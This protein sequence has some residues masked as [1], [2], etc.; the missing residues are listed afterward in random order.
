MN[1][2]DAF[3]PESIMH[4]CDS[5]AKLRGILK[6]CRVSGFTKDYSESLLT[7]LFSERDEIPQYTTAT[8]NAWPLYFIQDRLVL[9]PTPREL[10]PTIVSPEAPRSSSSNIVAN[11]EKLS[12]SLPSHW[13]T[14]VPPQK[15]II[16]RITDQPAILPSPT[17][18]QS[19]PYAP[20]LNLAQRLS[21]KLR[22][23]GECDEALPPL[24]YAWSIPLRSE[25]PNTHPSKIS[26][27]YKVWASSPLSN[28][29]KVPSAE[30]KLR[31]LST[32]ISQHDEGV[33]QDS[34]NV[35]HATEEGELSAS[36]DD[37][38]VTDA[39][40]SEPADSPEI[41]PQISTSNQLEDR[42]TKALCFQ[43]IPAAIP[44]LPQRIPIAKPYQLESENS[45]I[46]HITHSPAD[47]LRS[48]LNI[49][50]T[51]P[52]QLNATNS[53]VL[54]I[55]DTEIDTL[56]SSSMARNTK[57]CQLRNAR[58]Q[59]LDLP[60]TA[61]VFSKPPTSIQKIYGPKLTLSRDVM[62]VATTF[63]D[64]EPIIPRILPSFLQTSLLRK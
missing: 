21:P 29:P 1:T 38:V 40:I 11:D 20:S 53:E 26:N 39:Y 19:R 58:S 52:H 55:P 23:D 14:I 50:A 37:S 46:V 17:T 12:P 61:A 27:P 9:S 30:P 63:C 10:S 49:R 64:T 44:S 7:V 8:R 22:I 41:L 45:E 15:A 13:S 2:Q 57:R 3:L 33:V 36:Y 54:D 48:P 56:R 47:N 60:N 32:Y 25:R 28:P 42:D 4:I 24:P 62:S 31:K 34:N 43:N 5:L 16:P 18:L 51:K 35:N 6:E 59:M